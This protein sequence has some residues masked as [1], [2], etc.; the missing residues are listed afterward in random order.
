M[1]NSRLIVVLGMHRSGTSAVTRA[2]QVMNVEL[3][4]KL[5]P[6]ADGDNPKG[7]F[8][9]TDIYKLNVEMLQALR[10]DWYSL[11]PIGEHD[12]ETL[13]SRAFFLRAVELLNS[14]CANSPVFAFK[15]PRIAKLLPFW[16]A[17][18]DHCQF[19]VSYVVTVRHP[20]SVAN[21]LVKRNG[22][23]LEKGYLLWLEYVLRIAAWTAGQRCAYVD[24][25]RL[26]EQPVAQLKRLA[27]VLALKVNKPALADYKN[28]FLDQTLRHTVYT[29][30]DLEVDS[31]CPPLAHE[32]Y[33][34]ICDLADPG[35]LASASLN[36]TQVAKWIA[37]FS[38]LKTTLAYVDRLS[39]D[40]TVRRQNLEFLNTQVTEL[41]AE[42]VARGQWGLDLDKV[43]AERDGQL[44]GLHRSLAAGAGEI[45]HL[46]GAV[47]ERDITLAELGS[48]I[49]HIQAEGRQVEQAQVA[50]ANQLVLNAASERATLVDQLEVARLSLQASEQDKF[51]LLNDHFLRERELNAGYI[52]LQERQRE[53]ERVWAAKSVEQDLL[54]AQERRLLQAQIDVARSAVASAETARLEFVTES[55]RRERL[56]H[57]NFVTAQTDLQLAGEQWAS[58]QAEFE[59][60]L[61]AER[62]QLSGQIE[63]VRQSLQ[64]AL[65]EKLKLSEQHSLQERELFNSSTQRERE[66]NETIASLQV[67]LRQ[68]DKDWTDEVAQRDVLIAQ[69]QS[70]LI[71]QTQAANDA[72][73][74]LQRQLDRASI[75][76]SGRETSAR[77]EHADL[78]ARLLMQAASHADAL[79]AQQQSLVAQET[80]H[81]K[82]TLA[83]EAALHLQL[84]QAQ[85]DLQKLNLDA[86]ARQATSHT[87]LLAA[88]QQGLLAHETLH[89]KVTVA[90][91]AALHW[92][93]AQ[94]TL[95]RQ[96]MSVHSSTYWRLTSPLRTL[97][98]WL[99]PGTIKIFAQPAQSFDIPS[100][101]EFAMTV[102]PSFKPA[103]L[104][105]S[106]AS[107]EELT[108][109]HDESFIHAAYLAV[110]RRT[111]DP[112]GWGY[113]LN[114]LRKGIDKLEILSQLRH[115][116]EGQLQN[117]KIPDLE[118]SIQAFTR[119]K[120]SA[121][122]A[123][124]QRRRIAEAQRMNALENQFQRLTHQ[125]AHRFDQVDLA[126][127]GLSQAAREQAQ[128]SMAATVVKDSGYAGLDAWRVAETLMQLNGPDFID[129]LFGVTLG[130]PAEE[131]E[132]THYLHLLGLS[133]SKL[134]VIT[135]LFSSSECKSRQGGASTISAGTAHAESIT[136][137][138]SG[139]AELIRFPKC[140][141]P[142][143]SVV[144]PVYGKLN[145]TLACLQA[146]QKNLPKV[147]FEIIVVD[148]HSPDNTLIELYKIDSIR[149]IANAENRGFI[150]SCNIGAQ[151]ACGSFICFLNNDT[152]VTAG[153]LDE[154]V[155]TFHAFPGTGF[156]GSKLI[157]PDGTLQEAGG[158]LW[159]DG[160][161]WNFGR[162][163]DA[164]LPV[165]NYAREVDYCSGASVM[166]PAALFKE[167]EGFDV[168]YLPAYCEDSDLALKIRNRGLR[169][170]YQPLSVVVHHEG[171]SSGTDTNQGAKAYQIENTKKLYERWKLHLQTHQPNGV[172]VDRA[173]DRSA[174]RRALVI[175]H[176]TPTPDQDAGSITVLNLMLLLRE[177]GFQVT[178]IPEDNFLYMPDYTTA[179][180]RVGI[181]VLYAPYVSSVEQHA[182]E[183]GDRY[184][185]AFLFRP[186]VVERHLK[187]IRQLLPKAKVLYHTVDLHF[188]RMSREAALLHGEKKQ[189]ALAKAA[190]MKRL[191]LHAI[192][193]VDA[194]IVHSTAEHTLLRLD[195]PQANIHIFPL[196]M[197]LEESQNPFDRRK[198]IV[199]IGGYQHTPNVDAVLYF[200]DEIM[201]LIRKSLPGVCFFAVGSKPPSEIQ[202]LACEDV[203]ISGY[204]DDLSA[205]L[206]NMRVSVAP[207][208]FGAGVKGKIG[209]AMA[210]G[211]P[212]VTTAIGAE[213]M[214]LTAGENIVIADGA[215]QFCDAVVKLYLNKDLWTEVCQ[216]G[217]T[218]AGQ[219][220]GA[221]AAWNTLSGI[222]S[223]LDIQV[224]PSLRPLTLYKSKSEL[225]RN[226]AD[227]AAAA[228]IP[229]TT[230]EKANYDHKVE[231]ELAIF[232]KQEKVHDLPA[233]F[234][235]WSNKFLLPILK[236]A[237]HASIKGF[238]VTALFGSIRQNPDER[239]SFLSIGAGNCDLE[240]SIARDLVDLG[241]TEF[242][243]E[244][245]ELNP[246]MLERAARLAESSGV[247]HLMHLTLADFN[248]W[249][250][251]N[252]YSGVMANQSL[253]H[254]SD[255]EHLF[256]QIQRTLRP[257]GSF[258][259]VDMIGR[260][261]HQRWPESLSLIQKFWVEL[262]ED[263]KFNLLL[264]RHEDVYENWDCSK[265]GFEG[266]RSQEVLP[267][268]L[269]SFVCHQ[270]IGFGSAI[271]IFIDRCF[272][273]HFDRDSE[274]DRDF[275]D[276]VHQADEDGLRS[277]TLTPTHMMAVF[278]MVPCETPLVSR[279]ITPE[280]SVRIDIK[281]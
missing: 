120:P 270:F 25:D 128:I 143:V 178:F 158:I 260:N 156:V 14:K 223:T 246:V 104:A 38:R 106:P 276:R 153:W 115:S 27:K 252:T 86:L 110:L 206:R 221:E 216:N 191:E 55:S 34:A 271:D 84:A 95:R 42:T 40:D 247:R 214:S 52:E 75:E 202:A 159:R 269:N 213:G 195:L 249:R 92:Q 211:L 78:Q 29:R 267:I 28:G 279:G 193:A 152:E 43:I 65:E 255:L 256:G 262:P 146:I 33:C 123:F 139:V 134:H 258:V 226:Y 129:R 51:K 142:L 171:I 137:A 204:V 261:G 60:L 121:L 244:C 205:L 122:K 81:E 4:D 201:P 91:E 198:D 133:V 281:I 277:G 89:E 160:S 235:Y 274:I 237:G 190:E 124:F 49:A 275:I 231:Q 224:A 97:S 11:A 145:Y 162:N 107:V 94:E 263:Y 166:V 257:A 77:L 217:L 173:K 154:L 83:R 136:S 54:A 30:A 131:Q 61:A 140:N 251:E 141:D 39:A 31:L 184:S 229:A 245:V 45:S 176:C 197:E 69:G 209:T 13:R 250:P 225:S 126:L 10:I 273:H 227:L 236:D 207:L 196:I 85:A 100:F 1:A 239:P 35:A 157:Y 116:K 215:K 266:I 182:R 37:E 15:D 199:F 242:T 21:S 111:P 208:R 26:V 259:V 280:H 108:A 268:L 12:V 232:S 170:I 265:E 22:F 240:V 151:A 138:G 114:R 72:V 47:A 6:A 253:H 68:L 90:R 58:K 147:A 150:H 19:G 56:L 220:W 9:D 64:A 80:L 71:S 41:K 7:F 161:A 113:Y 163:Q 230:I 188:L 186:S 17:V 155:R 36:K 234:H 130:R 172:D 76:Y 189:V 103:S 212:V 167:L 243:F 105:R 169:I 241:C 238:F 181:E 98:Q 125:S 50:A 44:A 73:Q 53:A 210:V 278:K 87:D 46:T 16:K 127:T 48:R 219:Q 74:S 203:V 70:T 168:Y 2:L 165:Y 200:V 102:P 62:A 175:D 180:Q 183:S 187:N 228:N 66:F 118:K 248:K 164:S 218:F 272:G 63:S 23:D 233:I 179:L 20:R 79:A 185:L 3:G 93:L 144:I 32:V 5:M 8:E 264:N 57:E 82:V 101:N 88:K 24:Y 112:D 194:C 67:A 177:M 18:F 99:A 109:L 96:L 135:L 119:L 222:L 254:V 132:S 117:L 59:R 174:V 192:T 148:D 149:V